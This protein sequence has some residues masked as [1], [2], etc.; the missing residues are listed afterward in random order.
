MWPQV[1][2]VWKYISNN[3]VEWQLLAVFPWCM[4]YFAGAILQVMSSKILTKGSW[5][6]PKNFT[7]SL[8]LK[9]KQLDMYP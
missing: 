1:S 2:Y 7:L 5:M 8:K 3:H 6:S 9:K 4:K